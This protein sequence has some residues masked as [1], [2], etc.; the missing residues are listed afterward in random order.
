MKLVLNRSESMGLLHDDSRPVTGPGR[1]V[2]KV[3][4]CA[5]CR[6]DAKMWRQGHR[7][8]KLPRVLGHEV[9]AVD[10]ATGAL[11]TVWPGE[12]C[13]NCQYCR[14]GRENLCDEMK[15]TGFHTDGG[16]A[17]YLSVAKSSLIEVKE[18]MEPRYVTFCE[19]V[20]C[21]INGLS[22]VSAHQGGKVVV[23]GGGVL[24]VLAALVL[25]EKGYRVVVIERSQE[26]IGRIKV[27][28]DTNGISVVKDSV[29]ADFDLAINCCD[30]HIAFSLCIT[31]LKKSGKLIFFSGLKKNEELD[32]NLLNLIHYKELEIYGA[33]GP[34]REH[35]VEALAFC[36]RQQDNLAM[37]VEEV[38]R[39]EEVERVLPHVLSGNSLKYIVD[40]KKA[41]SAE[42]DSWVQPED[43]TF[44][45]RVKNDLPGFLGEIAAKIEPLSDEMRHSARKKVDL[46]TKPLGALGTIEELAVQL[47]T[48]Q[49]TLDPAVPCRRMFVF[50]GDHGIVEEGVSAFPAKV[51]VQMV[52]N[53]LDGGAAINSFCRQYG[54]ELSVVDMGVNG[55]FAAH[56]LLID[57]KVAYGTENFALGDAMTRKQALCA[58]ENGARVFLE[59]NQQS[60]CQLVGMG[61]MGI[62]NT[63]SASAIICAAT[64]LTPEQVVGRG[65]GVDDRGLERKREVIEKALDLHRPSG[66]NG[67][68][69]LCKMG[70]YELAGICGAT[71]AAA[72]SGCCVVLDGV[73]STA[74][75]LVACLICPAVGPYL[76][77]GHK[78]IEI[79]QRAALE[80]MGLEP[81]V[82]LGFR[83]GEGTGAAVT[84]N[85]VDLACRM[86]REMASFE[87]A[88]VSTGNDH[89]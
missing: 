76:I 60:P 46:K 34:R 45:P 43:K 56:P 84:M 81:V 78:S 67:L 17:T 61:E 20:G 38:I 68:E 25:R 48:I 2:L 52:D 79:G 37:L 62:G 72:A 58:I 44:E 70:G 73:I 86:M 1:A 77:A 64:R 11:Y 19:P 18:R 40:L 69:L 49:Q 89:G 32:T 83:L 24:G 42:A 21:V 13:G 6:T 8:L 41:P 16:F 4:C 80:L 9:A 28:C 7:D 23:Y 74:A 59:K 36:S 53:F 71:L 22:L 15:I 47:S 35:M 14:A 63:T 85:L 54:I 27:V 57:K 29:E 87:E 5:V 82:D 88:G 30:S 26:K 10:E 50:A 31:K 39:V 75:G 12:S 65:T 33:Y 55:D 51:T 66:D 3:V